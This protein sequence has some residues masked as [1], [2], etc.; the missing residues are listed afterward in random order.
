MKHDHYLPVSGRLG[1]DAKSFQKRGQS[2]KGYPRLDSP[3]PQVIL[4]RKSPHFPA[5][6]SH[7]LTHVPPGSPPK[8]QP[9]KASSSSWRH[10]CS[11]FFTQAKGRRK[12]WRAKYECYHHLRPEC[13]FA[14][15]RI[16]KSYHLHLNRTTIMCMCMCNS[17]SIQLHVTKNTHPLKQYK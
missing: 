17:R 12:Q 1:G 15:V 9:P 3:R 13:Q 5:N 4:P 7:H 2:A 10:P 16:S 6:R 14:S 11:S 8:I